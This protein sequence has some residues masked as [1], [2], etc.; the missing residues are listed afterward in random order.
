V[1]APHAFDFEF[2]ITENQTFQKRR[3]RVFL[4]IVTESTRTKSDPSYDKSISRPDACIHSENTAIL[5]EAKTQ[6]PLIREQNDNHIKHFLGTATDT[7]RIT[8]EMISERLK[9]L[10]TNL[11]GQDRFLV[12]QFYDFLDLIGVSAFDGFSESDFTML[13]SIGKMTTEDFIDFKRIF[14]KK[15]E[16]FMEQLKKEIEPIINTNKYKEY[17]MK[18][19]LNSPGA[20]SAFYFYDENH[21]QQKELH[22]L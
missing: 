22:L 9:L 5:I 12:S 19:G 16:K 11:T 7:H 1:S 18:G 2:Q 4:T 15:T 17:I 3:N 10:K 8:W 6:S 13:G 21:Y 14:L 20:F